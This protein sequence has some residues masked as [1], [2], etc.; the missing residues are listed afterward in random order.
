[1]EKS[2]QAFPVIVLSGARQTGK[3]TFLQCEFGNM[4]YITVDDY[5]IL[6]QAKKDPHS[7]W[8]GKREVV[9]D[10]VQKAPEIISAIK[11][12]VDRERRKRK[13]II[14]GSSNLLL[15]EKVTESLAGRA[16]YFEMLPLLYGEI[17]EHDREKVR[18]FEIWKKNFA[19]EETEVDN[20]ESLQF[21]S[22]W[23]LRGFMPPLIFIQE[24]SNILLWW[25]S[26]IRTYLERDLRELSQVH[27]LVDFRNLLNQTEIARDIQ[28]N[29][30]TVFRYMKLLEVSSIIKRIPPIFPSRTKRII[31]S[32]KIYFI[33][34]GLAIY[35][36]GYYELE[37]LNKSKELCSFFETMVFLHLYA[38]GQLCQ[39]KANLHYLRTTTGSE[40]DFV[41][42]SGRKIIP[43]ECKFTQKPG[44]GDIKNLLRFIDANPEVHLGFLLHTGKK[45]GYLHRK[46]IA[47]PWWWL[48][49]SSD[50]K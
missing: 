13:F 16:A 7:L 15:M 27:S 47:A 23:M 38:L 30:P 2:L 50:T 42:E 9:I 48:F 40:V 33:D 11:I 32:P 39:P 18:F 24:S 31:K 21:A 43:F 14:S 3:S 37:S 10:E 45:I 6:S 8:E 22:E 34:P 41:L 28:L 36:S 25:D 46:V 19:V 49:S 26:Y 17:L 20:A 5:D 44:Y 1:M 29:Q 4:H 35:L 12:T